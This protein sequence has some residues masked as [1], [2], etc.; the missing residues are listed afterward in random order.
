MKS[1]K[2]ILESSILADVEDTMKTGDLFAEVQDKLDFTAKFNKKYELDLFSKTDHCKQP[3][4]IGDLIL[5][6]WLGAIR[7]GVVL[8][9][10]DDK[11]LTVTFDGDTNMDFNRYRRT[12]RLVA[13]DIEPFRAIKCTDELIKALKKMI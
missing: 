10:N 7:P 5:C 13:F 1:F 11:K 6:E 3:I 12:K 4:A 2:N 8:A 9:I